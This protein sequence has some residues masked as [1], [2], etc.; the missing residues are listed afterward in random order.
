MG[1][2][3]LAALTVVAGFGHGSRTAQAQTGATVYIGS[4]KPAVEVNLSVLDQLGKKPSLPGLLRDSTLGRLPPNDIQ[5][6]LL[7]RNQGSGSDYFSTPDNLPMRP[8][9]NTAS[10]NMAVRIPKP[11]AT[12]APVQ[13]SIPRPAAVAA[14]SKK[15][16]P[17]AAVKAPAKVPTVK[18]PTVKVEA[19]EPKVEPLKTARATSASAPVAAKPAAAKPAT[20]KPAAASRS[21]WQILFGDGEAELT[22]N[23]QAQIAKI[24]AGVGAD[25]SVVLR[26]RAH[27]DGRQLGAGNARRLALSRALKVRQALA[28]AGFK[29][30]RLKL[31]VI[32]DR[33]KST[34]R[35]RVDI[36][37]IKN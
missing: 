29:K 25:S 4:N 27:A 28:N 21:D 19:P 5:E 33:E 16:V 7:I 2:L 36:K 37:R 18:V 31:E 11:A 26:I 14:V 32:G 13:S 23:A 12:I 15:P 3:T 8:V 10:P 9:E 20:S 24:I 30:S 17:L 1:C 6:A 35:D 34:P 22:S